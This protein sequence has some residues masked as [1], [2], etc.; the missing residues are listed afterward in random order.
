MCETSLQ[1]ELLQRHELNLLLF[2]EEAR[3]MFDFGFHSYLRHGFPKA[4]S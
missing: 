2:R 4:R 1:S 3:S